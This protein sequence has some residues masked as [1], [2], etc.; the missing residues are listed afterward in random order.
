M[1]DTQ[2]RQ[3]ILIADDNPKNLNLLTAV[4]QSFGHEVRSVINGLEAVESARAEPPDLILLDIMMPVMDGYE[5][6]RLLKVNKLTKDIPVIFV[7]ALDE[8]FN[9]V[10]GFK[11]GAVDY[12]TKPLQME[13]ARSRVQVHLDL[14]RRIRELEEFNK[15][16]LDREMRLIEL[17]KEV[18]EMAKE[19]GRPRPYD[20][21]WND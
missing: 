20:E 13:E 19:C 21:V 8:S 14:R 17:K 4:L 7:S 10:K 12:L 6:C 15:I 1:D 16:M 11:L 9:K 18:N 2:T 3:T 5:A